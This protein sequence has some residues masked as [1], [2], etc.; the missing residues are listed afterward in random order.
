MKLHK[1]DMVEVIWMDIVHD[2]TWQSEEDAAKAKPTL[3]KSLGY[4]LNRKGRCLRISESLNR[5][6]NQR[7]VQVMPLGTVLS[8]KKLKGKR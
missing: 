1:N 6:L 2:S 3:C 4:Y 7:S 8:I 5:D